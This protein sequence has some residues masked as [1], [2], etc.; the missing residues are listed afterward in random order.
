MRKSDS[1]VVMRIS[2][3]CVTS[4]RRSAGGV[5]PDRTPTDTSGTSRPWAAA[6][7]AMPT[8]GARRL[9]S[10]STPSAF[11]GERYT[12]FV[13]AVTASAPAWCNRSIAQRNAASVLPE[14]VGAT[15]RE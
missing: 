3:G 7:R 12:T 9:R 13:P 11:S 15:T 14:P 4:L 2:G 1:G 8:R 5:S 10:T 6:V